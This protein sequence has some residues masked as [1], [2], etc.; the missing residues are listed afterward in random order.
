MQLSQVGEAARSDDLDRFEALLFEDD[1][2]R[3]EK[4]FTL[5][6]LNAELARTKTS[7][8]LALDLKIIIRYLLRSS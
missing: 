5:I 6:A 4:Y 1:E 3:R 8:E 7:A 2:A